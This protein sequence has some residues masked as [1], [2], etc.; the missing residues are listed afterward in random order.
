MEL[1]CACGKKALLICENEKEMSFATVKC[2]NCGLSVF[3]FTAERAIERWPNVVS[4][5]C[6]M[7]HHHTKVFEI[8]GKARE[9]ICPSCL[10]SIVTNENEYPKFCVWCGQKIKWKD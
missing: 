4:K 9:S 6:P 10:G 3:G 8:S 7:E 2:Q 5:Q 1:D